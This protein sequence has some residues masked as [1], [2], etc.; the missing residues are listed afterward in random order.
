MGGRQST[1]ANMHEGL[2]IQ[3][4]LAHLTAIDAIP[5]PKP[6][7]TAQD[8]HP[9]ARAPA[10]QATC[11]RYRRLPFRDRKEIDKSAA[12]RQH[13]GQSDLAT[14]LPMATPA[15][16]QPL[17]LK[18]S[19]QND[20]ADCCSSLTYQDGFTGRFNL[21]FLAANVHLQLMLRVHPLLVNRLCPIPPSF[22]KCVQ[23]HNGTE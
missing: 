10:R 16:H 4:P 19:P 11:V 1:N 21:R 2:P 6:I 13:A 22:R 9:T 18:G 23:K 14:T 5:K 12:D 8:R 20:R 15:H 17:C 7:E 3:F